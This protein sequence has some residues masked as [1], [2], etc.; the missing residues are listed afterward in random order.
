MTELAVVNHVSDS[1]ELKV[2][3]GRSSKRI[4]AYRF[5]DAPW[6]RAMVWR[7]RQW[8]SWGP[9]SGHKFQSFEHLMEFIKETGWKP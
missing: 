2:T 4:I 8:T 3:D 9:T 6:W 1:R 5:N 7:G